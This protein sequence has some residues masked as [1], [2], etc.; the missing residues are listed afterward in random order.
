MDRDQRLDQYLEAEMRRYFPDLTDFW[1]G[2]N[3]TDCLTL[4]FKLNGAPIE[5]WQTEDNAGGS[6]EEWFVFENVDTG[7]Y[8]TMPFMEEAE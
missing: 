1:V 6:D 7:R 2:S 3:D 8:I 4:T 5:F